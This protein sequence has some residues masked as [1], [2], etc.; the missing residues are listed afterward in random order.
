MNLLKKQ[1]LYQNAL[2]SENFFLVREY[3]YQYLMTNEDVKIGKVNIAFS[4]K[5]IE[6]EIE[7]CFLP[8]NT[9]KEEHD[10]IIL[11]ISKNPNSIISI[12]NYLRYKNIEGF[13]KISGNNPDE[14]YIKLR[15]NNPFYLVNFEGS[16]E[17]R[18]NHFLSYIEKLSNKY[19]R[20]ILKGK[21]WEEIPFDWGPYK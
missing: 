20:K 21:D 1:E 17:S 13:T 4:K 8:L 10:L 2:L 5:T 19:L 14:Y 9:R 3:G 15:K 16:F 12:E 18:L 11:N 6:R 7:L